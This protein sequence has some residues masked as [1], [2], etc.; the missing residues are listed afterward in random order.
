MGNC[1]ERAAFINALN[2]TFDGV[3]A[4]D[5]SKSGANAF[6]TIEVFDKAKDVTLKGGAAGI[7]YGD[8]ARASYGVIINA[9]TTDL[10]DASTCWAI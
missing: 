7:V 10:V 5:A 1:R 8:V 3:V 4:H 6:P 2:V 9:A